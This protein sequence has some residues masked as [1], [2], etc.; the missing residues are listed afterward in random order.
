MASSI[1]FGGSLDTDGDPEYV[2]YNALIAN[3]RT[4]AT[5]TANPPAR[6]QET[7][8][9]PIISDASKYVFSIV[10]ANM[11][12]CGKDLPIFIPTIRQGAANP[13]QNVDLTIYSVT[14]SLQANYTVLGNPYSSP[15]FLS[16]KPVIWVTEVDDNALAPIPQPAT[17]QT[18]QDISTLYYYCYTYSHWL[19]R[20]NAAFAAVL[21]DLQ[22]QFN[23]WWVA[24]AIPGAP[25]TL[26]TAATSMTYNPSTGLFSLY[27]SRYSFGGTDASSFGG[28]AAEASKLWFN[29]NMYGLMGN[30]DAQTVNLSSE[31][32]YEIIIRNILFQNILSVVPTGKSYWITIQD[33]ESTST[34]WSPIESIVFTSTMMPLVFEQTGDPVRYGDALVGTITNTQVA[35]SPI[36]TDI[37]LT[38]TNASDYRGFVQYVPSAEY[39]LT[40]FQRSKTQIA[41]IDVQIFWK[42]RLN[43]QLYP[44]QMPN[45]SSVSLK[46]MFRRISP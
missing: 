12:G 34:L 27:A 32:A 35:F 38:N 1:T 16:T 13:T 46:M 4:T 24:T 19:N 5:A 26:G 7:R 31:R 33:Y 43:G 18:G 37:A 21:A 3:T 45:G 20:V 41:N 30:F 39:R 23:A 42:N 11:N 2:Y 14:Q 40:A 6:F 28:L 25:P 10:R 29:S 22:A 44:V 15:V 17:T 36:I 8:G 9:V